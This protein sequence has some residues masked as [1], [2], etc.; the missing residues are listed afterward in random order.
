MNSEIQKNI[1]HLK[2]IAETYPQI[3]AIYLFGSAAS[4]N[5]GP[6]SD[7]D[8]GIFLTEEISSDCQ[9]Q[10]EAQICSALKTDKVD[11]VFLNKIPLDAA[12]S[13]IKDG[14][15]LYDKDRAKLAEIIFIMISRYLDM[16][17]YSDMYYKYRL[18]Q[19]G[20]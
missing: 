3:L 12:Y 11:I 19:I 5:T 16:K 14:V 7:I 6:L 1:F 17:Y 15:C 18:G 9:L 4:G 8:L 10:L 13:I 2:Q 20:K